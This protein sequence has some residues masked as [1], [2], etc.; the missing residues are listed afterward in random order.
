[1]GRKSPLWKALNDHR[2]YRILAFIWMV[3]IFYLSSKSDLPTPSLFW[4]QDKL[5][6]A[7]IFGFLGLLYAR[8]LGPWKGRLTLKQVALVSS[9]VAAYGIFDECHQMFVAN[10]DPSF[11]DFA[12]DTLGGLLVA[13]V[14]WRRDRQAAK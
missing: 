7:C 3:V 2:F 12:A 14:F 5:A 9:M 10:R 1:L 6:H 13:L 4:G 8:S 11:A